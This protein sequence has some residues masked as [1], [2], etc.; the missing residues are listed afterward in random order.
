MGSL[1]Q[2]LLLPP[3]LSILRSPCC[4]LS[5]LPLFL[6]CIALLGHFCL[7]KTQ[8]KVMTS[9]RCEDPCDENQGYCMDSEGQT[10]YFCCKNGKKN[11]EMCAGSF[12]GNDP[13]VS[14]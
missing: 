8:A 4:S 12:S 6:L 5:R 14:C 9:D 2:D 11:T 10:C 7:P 3:C 13:I 1:P